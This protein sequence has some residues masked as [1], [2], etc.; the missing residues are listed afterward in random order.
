[1]LTINSCVG[2]VWWYLGYTVSSQKYKRKESSAC[3]SLVQLKFQSM[4][5][6]C[7]TSSGPS[8]V[9]GGFILVHYSSLMFTLLENFVLHFW[10]YV[11]DFL[12]AVLETSLFSAEPPC[13]NCPV[14]CA[15]VTNFVCRNGDIY[16]EN[17]LLLVIRF[18][19][20]IVLF[21]LLSYIHY[22][23]VQFFCLNLIY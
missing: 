1:M 19:L 2:M 14:R 5:Q 3:I 10:T 9:R 20:V 12:F 16:L 18:Y 7:K 15:S 17:K 8:H 6:H 11:F 13:K 23:Y 4:I 22:N 21:Y